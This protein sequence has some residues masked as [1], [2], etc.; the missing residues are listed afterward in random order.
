[1]IAGVVL[2]HYM[3]AQKLGLIVQGDTSYKL[4]PVFEEE[5]KTKIIDSPSSCEEGSYSLIKDIILDS[6]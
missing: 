3:M 5:I 1:V 6:F 2:G 4:D